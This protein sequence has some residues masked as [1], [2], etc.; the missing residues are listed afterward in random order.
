MLTCKSSNDG[1]EIPKR[2]PLQDIE[3][4][5]E[6]G[7]LKILTENGAVSFY[8]YKDKYLG[9]EYDILDTFARSIGVELEV[10]MISNPEDFSSYI[11]NLS[12]LIKFLNKPAITTF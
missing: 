3:A 2:P 4:I 5:Q 10:E 9:F 6:R 11:F 8:K 12:G 7:T 1:G